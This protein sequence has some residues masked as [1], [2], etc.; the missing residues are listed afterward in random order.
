MKVAAIKMEGGRAPAVER[1]FEQ[2]ISDLEECIDGGTEFS[3]YQ[4]IKRMNVD[5]RW[6]CSS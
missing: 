3:F 2:H 6:T 1:V 5:D 4:N